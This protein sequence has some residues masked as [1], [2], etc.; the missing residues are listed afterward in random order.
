V[1]CD[2]RTFASI[3][4]SDTLVLCMYTLFIYAIAMS[5]CT[6]ASFNLTTTILFSMYACVSQPAHTSMRPT[7]TLVILRHLG[8][9]VCVCVS[10]SSSAS[11]S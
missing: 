6:P 9:K 2:I 10:S 1:E 8:F 7:H 11:Y 4:V 3:I 5:K